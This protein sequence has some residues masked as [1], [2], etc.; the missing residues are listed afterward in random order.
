MTP[1]EAAVVIANR[2]RLMGATIATDLP[3]QSFAPEHWFNAIGDIGGNPSIKNMVEPYPSFATYVKSP[4]TKQLHFVV[5]VHPDGADTHV[6]A[7][8]NNVVV[9]EYTGGKV[10]DVSTITI[11]GRFSEYLVKY[12]ILLD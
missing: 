12:I 4:A 9:D 5:G 6:F 8:E 7:Y 10:T 3:N 11:T 1:T 2:A